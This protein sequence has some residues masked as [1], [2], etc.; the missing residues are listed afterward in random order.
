M[1]ECFIC[2]V[3]LALFITSNSTL[4]EICICHIYPALVWLEGHKHNPLS[5]STSEL[6]TLSEMDELS[7]LRMYV[8]KSADL[9]ICETGKQTLSFLCL[10]SLF[11]KVGWQCSCWRGSLVFAQEVCSA[12]E[13]LSL[14]LFSVS[15]SFSVTSPCTNCIT[16]FALGSTPLTFAS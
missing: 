15:P 8:V 7:S 9:Q 1:V 13:T 16:L 5:R 2:A 11:C 14:I 4:A 10:L 12:D 6:F 3:D